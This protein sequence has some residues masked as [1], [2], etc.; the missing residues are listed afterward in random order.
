MSS[1]IVFRRYLKRVSFIMLF[2]QQLFHSFWKLLM[3]CLLKTL[4][5]GPMPRHVGFI[6]DGNRRFAKQRALQTFKGHELGFSQ[7]ENVCEKGF[8]DCV[9]YRTCRLFSYIICR[10]N[11]LRLNLCT[12][13]DFKMVFGFKHKNSHSVCI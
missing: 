2:L 10:R 13:L 11:P 1:G 6:M 4:Q 7:L 9:L 5:L 3:S 12:I 8:Q